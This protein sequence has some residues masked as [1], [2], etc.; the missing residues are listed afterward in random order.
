[1]AGNIR[2]LATLTALAGI[3]LL[4]IVLLV[5]SYS[6][7]GVTD[8]VWTGALTLSAY[9]FSEV[10]QSVSEDATRLAAELF[11]NSRSLQG[12]QPQPGDC[13]APEG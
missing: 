8:E 6:E 10:P 4:A 7:V 5:V 12:A 9:D 2:R 11:G 3:L 1:M 13:K